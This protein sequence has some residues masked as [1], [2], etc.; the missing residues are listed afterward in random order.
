MPV[1]HIPYFGAKSQMVDKIWSILPPHRIWVDVFGG[2]GSVTWSK[3]KSTVEIYND[4]GNVALFF[5]VLRDNTDELMR[6]I[7]LTCSSRQEK[8]ECY[9]ILHSLPGVYDEVEIARAFF[10]QVVQSFRHTEDDKTWLNKFNP[11][12]EKIVEWNYFTQMLYPIAYRCKQM[13]IERKDFRYILDRYDTK[14]TLFYCDPPYDLNSRKGGGY[15]HE[16]TENDQC[17]LLASL[18]L[19]QGNAIVSGYHSDIYDTLLEDW[20]LIEIIKPLQVNPGSQK[21][22]KEDRVECLWIKNNQPTL[23]EINE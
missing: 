11:D 10:V 6:R 15:E 21:N 7:E 1:L 19:I 20:Q 2:G 4:V 8:E 5:R 9:A 22:I 17:E 13:R 23:W 3:P 18:S 16:L 14:E 12:R